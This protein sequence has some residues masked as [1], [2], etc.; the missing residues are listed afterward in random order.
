MA[1][2]RACTAQV[3]AAQSTVA[4]YCTSADGTSMQPA[5]VTNS[6]EV[7]RVD[8][9]SPRLK[10]VVAD[11][12][13]VDSRICTTLE[14]AVA[15]YPAK[16]AITDKDSANTRQADEVAADEVAVNSACVCTPQ[17]GDAQSAVAVHCTSVDGT[18][19]QPAN[20]TN[21]TE[22]LRVVGV[23]PRVSVVAFQAV[24]AQAVAHDTM[25]DGVFPLVAPL[26]L[27]PETSY[28]VV[29][30]DEAVVTFVVPLWLLHRPSSR[31][32]PTL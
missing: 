32:K 13:L 6:M 23:S 8:G 21:L 17:V 3:V 30:V 11:G 16:V 9:G 19:R 1:A 31:Q 15:H 7:L 20:V 26:A 14:E 24:A 27:Q 18:S 4:V 22:A 28:Q 2:N 5:S 29:V 10:A 12:Q 25:V